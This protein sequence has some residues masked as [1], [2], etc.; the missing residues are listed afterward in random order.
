MKKSHA[1]F[2]LCVVAIAWGLSWPVNKEQL[3][4]LPPIWAVVARFSVG[5][6][7][8]GLITA[9]SGRLR[10]P[11]RQD[12]PVV[13]SIGLLHMV[14]F[15]A[16]CSIG[17]LYVTAGRS[18]LLAYTTPFWVFPLAHF[19]LG[20]AFTVRRAVALACGL[21]GLA[22]LANPAS[23]D[24]AAP[25]VLKGHALILLGA[26]VWA[27][28]IVYVRM[29]RWASSA[30]DLLFWQSLLATGVAACIAFAVE[31]TPPLVTDGYFLLLLVYSGA[32][33]IAVAFWALNTA[34]RALPATTTSL[35]LLGVP[36][37]GVASSV[38]ML[39]E[40]ADAITLA[41]MLLIVGGIAIGTIGTDRA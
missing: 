8:L 1:V 23:I 27:M 40:T 37:F 5:T 39:G 7:F 9:A 34:N 33:A 17:L 36:L 15:S 21:G 41:A 32:F 14:A 30:F 6:I 28:S 20:E 13:L 2:L 18:V 29:H 22:L 24:W 16:L 19:F 4:Y 11:P 35:G 3:I 38:I 25:G 31:G 26:V 12:I 10:P